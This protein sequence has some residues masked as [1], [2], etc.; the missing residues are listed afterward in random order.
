M[1]GAPSPEPTPTSAP[2][3]VA[4]TAA[5]EAPPAPA[6]A[7]AGGGPSLETVLTN[8]L[9]TIAE[10]TGYELE[11]IEPDMELEADL[12]IDTV[13]QA[14][15]FGEVRDAYGIARDD[16]FVLADYPTIEALAGWLHSMIGAPSPEPTPTS[17][18]ASVAETTAVQAPA[19]EALAESSAQTPEPSSSPEAMDTA[20]P[21]GFAL[22][23]P[24]WTRRE[25]GTPISLENTTMRVLGS[26]PLANSVRRKLK[27]LGATVTEDADW[28]IDLASGV[29][30]SFDIAKQMNERP[31][32][33]WVAVCHPA[34]GAIPSVA[35]HGARAGHAK[36]LGREWEKTRARV[37]LL[38]MGFSD[39]EA[40]AAITA[41]IACPD[42]GQE[43][44]LAKRSR[45]VL[46]LGVEPE[47][48]PAERP[49][50]EVVLVTGGGRGIT[51]M[52]AIELARRAPTTLVLVGRSPAGEAPLD[53]EKEKAAVRAKL[54]ASGE[55]V[56]PAAIERVLKPLRKKEEIRQT[57]EQI[58]ALGSKAEY[59]TC[60]MSEPDEVRKMVQSAAKRHGALHGCIHG[61]G[62]EE[63]RLL[64][65]KDEEAFQRVFNG[66][67]LGGIALFSSLPESAWVLSMGS[68]A[69]R[70][71]NAGQ[72]DYSAANE[73]MAQAC[74]LRPRSLHID[75][76]AWGDVGMAVRGGM[77]SLLE[78]RGV[79]LLPAGPGAALA[80]DLIDQGLEG[81]IL[82][83]GRLGGLLPGPEHPLVDSA[84]FKGESISLRRTLSLD[85]DAWITDH[86]IGGVPVLP[87]VIGVELMT[88]AA[89][90]IHPGLPYGGLSDIQFKAPVKMHRGEPVELEVEARAH[91]DNKVSCTLFSERILKTGKHLRTEHFSGVIWLGQGPELG[92]LVDGPSS[93][94]VV[95]ADAIYRRF[96][97][98]PI[99]QVLH[100]ATHLQPRSLEASG[101]VD[102]S[103]IGVPLA[104]QPLVLEA[105]FQA[106]GLHTMIV[107]GAL[108][109]P[110]SIQSLRCLSPVVEN[111]PLR[112]VVQRR[113]E[114]YDVDVH[115]SH[116]CVLQLRGYSMAELGPLPEEDRFDELA[117]SQGTKHEP[118]VGAASVQEEDPD[119]WLSESERLDLSQRGTAKRI[120][121]RIA[122]RIAA[123]RAIQRLTGAKPGT[124]RIDNN[125]SGAP[126]CRINDRPG[127][128]ISISHSGDQAVAL[129]SWTGQIGV[130]L[131]SIEVRSPSFIREWL[132]PSEQ[133][134][135]GQD[136]LKQN[137]AWSAKEAVFKAMGKG[138]ALNP[139]NL[140][141]E[142]V[143]PDQLEVSLHGDVA[144][145]HQNSGAGKIA[146]R[147]RV[148]DG[149]L[150]VDAQI[151]P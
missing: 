43:V 57:L 143:G 56:T 127:P 92:G 105:A 1:I 130:D 76:T 33:H 21:E 87:G 65:D 11:D 73:A 22:R 121:E 109:L 91:G 145:H 52:L 50:N 107:D 103:A 24:V 5:V 94:A 46:E 124:I 38:G 117:A 150:W 146:V 84:D 20:L 149:K 90:V 99:F 78:G 113:G 114:T 144:Q 61:A 148:F 137:L 119:A 53:E 135:V 129:A 40:A 42:G 116:G 110:S 101:S 93:S 79:Q 106:A 17:A 7:T 71:G 104:S 59:V 54:K 15:I 83:S 108:A 55:R 66:K 27:T 32:S 41:E 34:A 125:A 74:T 23:R 36:A 30:V 147:W 81:E 49:A 68:V 131:E 39:D 140:H 3:P 26:S 62:V 31:P 6:A 29:S 102:H 98:G 80:I 122:G 13:K 25:R 45:Q 120:A 16:S 60:D 132:S 35:S 86:A 48:S 123:K 151:T 58:R 70:F 112:L 115:Q 139:R 126:Y 96:F 9:E 85:S 51:A 72:V 77:Q 89:Q 4:E 18:P 69:G 142:A 2:A 19:A 95:D 133:A 47:A 10:K 67:A 37:I 138:M 28:V 128:A 141:L 8:L 97:H 14:E 82:V 134:L 88:A 100:S 44:T 75:W 111:S 12:G 64:A 136:P 118:A 63:S